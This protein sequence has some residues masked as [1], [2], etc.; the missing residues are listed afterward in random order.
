MGYTHVT[1]T[2]HSLCFS[3]LGR[4]C[5]SDGR[6][7]LSRSCSCSRSKP[8]GSCPL[9]QQCGR[10]GT[11]SS[12]QCFSSDVC[13]SG[14]VCTNRNCQR[15]TIDTTE[16]IEFGCSDDRDCPAGQSCNSKKRSCSPA[17]C[18]SDSEC[19]FG[20]GCRNKRCKAVETQVQCNSNLDC[21][22]GEI[23]RNGECRAK[24]NECNTDLDC[25]SGRECQKN[26]CRK[27]CGVGG[28]CQ[29]CSRDLDCPREKTCKSGTC[30]SHRPVP[31]D[32]NHWDG[33]CADPK[34]VCRNGV[35][36][37]RD[38][39]CSAR[40]PRGFCPPGEECVQG[41]CHVKEMDNKRCSASDS[42]PRGQICERSRCRVVCSQFEPSGFC[43][44]GRKCIGGLCVRQQ[45]CNVNRDCPYRHKCGKDRLCHPAGQCTPENP[46][47]FC[48]NSGEE[49]S[50]G[51]RCVKRCHHQCRFGQV[52]DE[53]RGECVDEEDGEQRCSIFN[54]KSC[55][56]GRICKRGRCVPKRFLGHHDGAI[57]IPGLLPGGVTISLG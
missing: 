52:C 57:H 37:S 26:K 16:P 54:S 3:M 17:R 45:S 48:E 49:C 39:Q 12:I 18:S 35:C 29:Q 55:P 10:G 11:C 28:E 56:E 47:G 15:A 27:S 9:G 30:V 23:C 6:C 40:N 50:T 20:F 24:R 32:A 21:L 38:R 4:T 7:S 51:G 42:C 36:V 43:P 46:D 5:C 53:N 25:S 8:L 13:P 1:Y 31:C 33:V 44:D 22:T 34:K 14:F 19:P 2:T 41:E